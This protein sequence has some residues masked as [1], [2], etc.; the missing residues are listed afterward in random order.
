MYLA[1]EQIDMF[2]TV[3]TTIKLNTNIFL[4]A[5]TIKTSLGASSGLKVCGN[6]FSGN[7]DDVTWSDGDADRCSGVNKIR[8]VKTAAAKMK[9][10]EDVI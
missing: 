4:I 7:L 3:G 8:K 6:T 5:G 2:H 10:K 1:G 9:F